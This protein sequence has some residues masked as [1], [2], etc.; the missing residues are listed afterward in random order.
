MRYFCACDLFRIFLTFE[1]NVRNQIREDGF[2]ARKI[3]MIYT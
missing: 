1:E 2:I 3:Q